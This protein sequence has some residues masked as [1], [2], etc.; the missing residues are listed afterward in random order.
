MGEDE[1]GGGLGGDAGE[2]VGVDAAD[3]RVSVSLPSRLSVVPTRPPLGAGLPPA[4]CL[5]GQGS[6]PLGDFPRVAPR[7]FLIQ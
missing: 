1:D 2:G 6:L 5:H 7:D 4:I 3:L